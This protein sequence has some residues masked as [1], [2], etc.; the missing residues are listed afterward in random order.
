MLEV[1]EKV[2]IEQRV[3]DF[4]CGPDRPENIHKWK[5][6]VDVTLS[7]GGRRR[8]QLDGV[9]RGINEPEARYDCLRSALDL[10]GIG[11]LDHPGKEPG[12]KLGRPGWLLSDTEED[13]KKEMI[14]LR[15]A[16]VRPGE[17]VPRDKIEGHNHFVEAEGYAQLAYQRAYRLK[18]QQV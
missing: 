10:R 15:Y 12:N 1:A 16:E 4:Y 13:A 3:T 14:A 9:Q 5:Y 2:Q 8:I 17:V 7:D 11:I 6:G 18:P